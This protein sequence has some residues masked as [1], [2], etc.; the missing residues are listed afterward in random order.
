MGFKMA[1][2]TNYKKFSAHSGVTL[3]E[4]AL[5]IMLL[6]IISVAVSSLVR[7]GVEGQLSQRTHENMQVIALNIMDDLR[8]DL[9]TAEKANCLG[10]PTSVVQISNGGNRMSFCNRDGQVTYELTSANQMYRT[11]PNGIVK[12]YNQGFTPTLNVLCPSGCFAV[13]N[14]QLQ[15]PDLRVQQAT[16]GNSLMDQWLRNVE[17]PTFGRPTYRMSNTSFAL[18]SATQ[19]Q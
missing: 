4:M 5:C 2:S 9:R 18:L 11:S 19:F 1:L 15:M 13:V 10:A 8:F 7:T 14:G 6:S 17:D 12:V 16:A 3:L